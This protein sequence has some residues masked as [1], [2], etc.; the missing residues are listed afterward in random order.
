MGLAITKKNFKVFTQIHFNNSLLL[1]GIVWQLPPKSMF[2][3]KVLMLLMKREPS[4]FEDVET[5]MT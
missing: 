3:Q 1:K 2:I 4:F 5:Q